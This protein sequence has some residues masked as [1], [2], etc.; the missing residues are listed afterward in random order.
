[1]RMT[2]RL[3]RLATA[4]VVLTLAA[5][6]TTVAPAAAASTGTV[7]TIVS[8]LD[9][10]RDLAFSPNGRLYVAEAGHGGLPSDCVSGGPE[11]A[12]CPGFTSGLSVVDLAA[13][14]AHRVVSGLASVSGEGGFAALGLDGISFLG[15]GTLYGI[16]ALASDVVPD[17]A[18]SA[19]ITAGLKAQLGRLIKANPS[20]RWKVVADVGHTDFVWS[21]EHQSLAPRD[22]PDANPYGVLALPG[23]QWVVD[24]GSN[25]IDRVRP[26]GRVTVAAFVPNAPVGDA[27]PTCLDRGPDGALYIGQLTAAGN[28]PGSS[29]VW[30]FAPGDPAPTVWAT[31]LTAVTG[32]G[33]GADGQ[34]YAVE[35]ST[36][37]LINAAP[38][39]GAVVRV[40]AHSTSPSV[41][42]SGLSFPGGFAA[43]GDGSLY[44]SNWSIA[45]ADSGGG[46][47]GQV[48]R[49]RFGA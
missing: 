16:M 25:T 40:P 27:V 29:R 32:C 24:A 10:P 4:A 35:F 5:L 8:G 30:R 31:G 28:A 18:F 15:N 41:V 37:G 9:N 23:A 3:G 17:G 19:E 43:A 26:N 49:I 34:F 47:T 1:M 7:T 39:T 36:L 13:G 48:V 12:L 42:A 2:A 21:G 33:F 45:P 11:G 46:P 20:G 14:R 44:V 6:A 38:G 22:F